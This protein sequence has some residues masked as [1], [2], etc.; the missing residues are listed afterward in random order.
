MLVLSLMMLLLAFFTFRLAQ[1][2]TDEIG[3]IILRLTGTF[4]LLVSLINA[5]WIVLL[6][7]ALTLFL[8]STWAKNAH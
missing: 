4:C 7:V 8:T 5:P 6:L 1:A 3:T 2:L